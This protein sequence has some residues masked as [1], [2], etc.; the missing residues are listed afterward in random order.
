V[1][2]IRVSGTGPAAPRRRVIRLAR[3]IGTLIAGAGLA[4][5]DGLPSQAALARRFGATRGTIRAALEVL[6]DAGLLRRDAGGHVVRHPDP[7][8][9]ARATLAVHFRLGGLS[10]S[11]IYEMR[12]LLEPEIAAQLAG[13]LSDEVLE[14]MSQFLRSDRAEAPHLIALGLHVRLAREAENPLLVFLIDFLAQ[15][16]TDLPD[17]DGAVAGAEETFRHQTRIYHLRLLAALRNG[18]AAGARRAMLDH[19]ES[20]Q[21]F[22]EARGSGLLSRYVA[23]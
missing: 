10:V 11:D 1:S 13:R 3:E 20:A 2:D 9:Q 15:I 5:G 16:L 23:E 6:E 17:A 19:L 4:S 8:R 14:E 21:H 12:C 18:H 22:L 7:V